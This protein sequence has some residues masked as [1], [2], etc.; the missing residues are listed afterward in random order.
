MVIVPTVI[1]RNLDSERIYDLYSCL[2]KERIIILTG[3]I[4]DAMASSICTQLLYLSSLSNEPIQIYINSNGGSVTA[5]LA[6]YDIM[7]HISCEVSTICM[8]MCA[9]MAAVL[10]A[11]GTKGKRSA[12]KNAEIMI[13][14]PLG[15]MQGQATDMEIAAQHI[16]K[17]KHKLTSLLVE[18]S[19]QPYEQIQQDCERDY[20]MSPEDAIAYGLI[21]SII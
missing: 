10:L 18:N 4:N 8:G 12:L 20:Y 14:Q 3:E 16:K 6:I 5:G 17:M 19:K 2:L 7:K 1:E 11:A 15:G 13:H 9:S 21:D